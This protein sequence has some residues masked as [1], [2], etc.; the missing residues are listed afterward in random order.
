MVSTLR[1][2]LILSTAGRQN[3]IVTV[4]HHV[5]LNF[6]EKLT[7]S[8]L[9]LEWSRN[10]QVAQ[11]QPCDQPDTSLPPQTRYARRTRHDLHRDIQTKWYYKKVS[12][13]HNGA[14]VRQEYRVTVRTHLPMCFNP[15]L[16]GFGV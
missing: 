13:I 5:V 4:R 9:V 8:L 12:S 6:F 14:L 1:R 2:V 16:T 15:S 11:M 10:N 7:I 3:K